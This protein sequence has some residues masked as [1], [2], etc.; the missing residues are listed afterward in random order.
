MEEILV[1][2]CSKIDK[3]NQEISFQ[4]I[5]NYKYP[6]ENYYQEIE[7]IKELK[8][9]KDLEIY[10]VIGKKEKILKLENET[11]E[12]IR[13]IFD[14]M[15][16]K[17]IEK[18]FEF[19]KDISNKETNSLERWIFYY[20]KNTIKEDD[21]KYPLVERYSSGDEIDFLC[22]YS[23]ENPEQSNSQTEDVNATINLFLEK[24][25]PYI[26]GKQIMLQSFL[27][28][29]I[30]GRKIISILPE[31]NTNG[32]YALLEGGYKL[33]I[34][35]A[36]LYELEKISSRDIPVC[37]VYEIDN[38]LKD[39]CYA[40]GKAYMSKEIFEEWNDVFLYALATLK[41][42][43]NKENLNELLEDFHEFIEK[44]V[45]EYVQATPIIDKETFLKAV[46]LNIKNIKGYLKGLEE[47]GI[48]R[49]ILLQVKNRY[50]Y[51]HTIY[52]IIEKRYPEEVK[53]RYNTKQFKVEEWKELIR[54]LEKGSNYEK[55]IHLEEIANYFIECIEGLNVSGR[56]VKLENQEID[57]CCY[58]LSE[59]GFLWELGT[60]ILVECKN[61]EKPV[62]T[63]EIRSMF[64]LMD[65]KGVD[66][67]ILFA[68][69]G[70]TSGAEEEILKQSIYDK[71]IIV[72]DEDD[73][74]ML[75]KKD[76]KPID[77]LK[78]KLEEL[79]KKIIKYYK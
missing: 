10:C 38:I 35:I 71:K 61:Y 31:K 62:E 18:S 37:T 45:C 55:G 39:S 16:E 43:Y 59:S 79:M 27:L 22:L 12:K 78:E 74:K 77:L 28:Q 57:L 5:N 3:E 65:A 42:E 7:K 47:T 46:I 76:K 75:E 25:N 63:K 8:D 13:K 72:I 23:S 66:T 9:E 15:L 73:L 4:Q 2:I 11:R 17:G 40:Y 33:P 21:I 24:E 41:I 70:I 51:L 67:F 29:N 53:N 26:L 64:Y 32:W 48:S 69:N 50:A 60:I 20:I 6:F 44:E 14:I 19:L 30:K 68:R 54:D 56:R 49:N 34:D 52:K 58:N 36:N 1:Y